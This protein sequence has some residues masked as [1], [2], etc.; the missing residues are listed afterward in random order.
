MCISFF[1]IKFLSKTAILS[2]KSVMFQ[3]L[4]C[5]IYDTGDW[6]FQDSLMGHMLFTPLRKEFLKDVSDKREGKRQGLFV[7][8]KKKT[9]STNQTKSF[10]P[11]SRVESVWLM[12][13]SCRLSYNDL[14][15][16]DLHQA[17]HP[18]VAF[19]SWYWG[20][21]PGLCGC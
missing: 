5:Y 15:K 10:P 18:T 8:G 21:D 16:K 13:N 17:L 12:P 3:A 4:Q 2:E 1:R 11:Q 14:Y 7:K 20:L 19:W 9:Q 6:N